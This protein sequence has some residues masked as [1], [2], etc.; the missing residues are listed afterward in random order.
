MRDPVCARLALLNWPAEKAENNGWQ[1]GS[2]KWGKE[3]SEGRGTAGANLP[4][5][6]L[7]VPVITP[8]HF[9]LPKPRDISHDYTLF[10]QFYA[11]LWLNL[12]AYFSRAAISSLL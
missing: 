4:Y 6:P 10:D 1:R 5:P 8:I 7:C 2:Y 12:A 9:L 3:L 11:V